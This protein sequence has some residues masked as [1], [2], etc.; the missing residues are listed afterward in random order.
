GDQYSAGAYHHTPSVTSAS[1]RSTSDKPS[2]R[3]KPW[4][5]LC[6][7]GSVS[8]S[9]CSSPCHVHLPSFTRLGH[10]D[11]VCPRAPSAIR[12]AAYPSN[13]SRPSMAYDRKP[14]PTLTTTA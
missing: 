10:G 9:C 3:T 4:M 12:S 14:P 13:R 7:S 11:N 5:A 8:A 1:D 2:Q 6:C